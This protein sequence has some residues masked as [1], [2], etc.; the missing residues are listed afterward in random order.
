[1]EQNT[2]EWLEHRRKGIGA[3]DIPIILGLSPYK[4]PYQLWEQKTGRSKDEDMSFQAAR[5]HELEPVARYAHF[6]QTEIQTEPALV[7]KGLFR[8]SLDGW[9]EEHK[10]VLEIK[11]PGKEDHDLALAGK[12]PE[13]YYYQVQQQ[14]YCADAELAHYYSF[15]GEAGAL[16]YCRRDEEAIKRIIEVGTHFWTFVEKDTPPPLSS[17]DYKK[18]NSGDMAQLASEFN[19]YYEMKRMADEFISRT[20]EMIEANLDHDRVELPRLK[21]VKVERKG[22]VD[23]SKIP[24]LAG[25][26]LEAYRKPASSYWKYTPQK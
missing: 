2:A 7:E 10:L 9:N 22:S 25:L 14:L 15:D 26:D 16:V 13:K 1:M 4:T 17:R 19:R 12:I 20:K 5:G 3:S 21:V 18:V 6:N 24:E 11:C 23:Y 8:A